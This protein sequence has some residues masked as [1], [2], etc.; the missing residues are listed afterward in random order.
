MSSDE[1]LS[2]PRALS[3]RVYGPPTP[4]VLGTLAVSVIFVI[5]LEF[6]VLT[7]FVGQR[8][9][10]HP[11]MLEDFVFTLPIALWALVV[12]VSIMVV[13]RII[14]TWLNITDNGFTVNGLFRRHVDAGWADVQCV[15]VVDELDRGITPTEVLDRSRLHDGVYVMGAGGK[16]LVN[17]SSRFFGPKAQGAMID[18][19]RRAD[20]TVENIACITPKELSKRES[21]AQTFVDTHPNLVLLGLLAF[22]LAHNVFTIYVWGV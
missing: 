14:T 5:V 17:V 19:A 15:L 16:R 2:A 13:A 18:H 7:S 3:T 20:V 22:Y 10:N 12:A 9:W 21:N 1:S 8:L 4:V 11:A 6:L